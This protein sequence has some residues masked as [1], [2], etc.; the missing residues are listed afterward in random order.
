MTREKIAA[1]LAGVSFDPNQRM[2]ILETHR[3]E[4]H[5]PLDVWMPV[6]HAVQVMLENAIAEVRK[7]HDRPH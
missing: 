4:I 1:P 6:M 3:F 5:I 2:V 7:A